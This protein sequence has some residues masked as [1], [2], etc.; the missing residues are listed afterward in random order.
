MKNDSS[1]EE[2][3]NEIHNQSDEYNGFLMVAL[4]F[5]KTKND[6]QGEYF[7]NFYNQKPA[8]LNYGKIN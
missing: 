2:Y 8:S 3:L 4:K 5:D 6:F 7:S 1:P